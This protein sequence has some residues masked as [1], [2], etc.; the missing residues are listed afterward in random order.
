MNDWSEMCVQLLPALLQQFVRLIGLPATLKLVEAHG[1]VRLYIP[2]TPLH[3]HPIAQKIGFDNMARLCQQY[4]AATFT[5][6]KGERA[7]RAIRNKK[8]YQEYG[9][10]STSQL[11]REHSLTERQIWNIMQKIGKKQPA[12]KSQPDYFI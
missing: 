7:L 9:P 5:I 4:P 8:I 1:G 3:D 10:K 6:F 11:A 2:E 12:N